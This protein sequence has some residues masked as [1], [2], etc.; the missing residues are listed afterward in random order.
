MR[1]FAGLDVAVGGVEQ[2]VDLRGP[3]R[4]GREL[5]GVEIEAQAE[6]RLRR[7]TH[8]DKR[9]QSLLADVVD[10]AHRCLDYPLTRPMHT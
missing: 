6:D 2:R 1:A 7:R 10:D 9:P 8:L 4:R 3:R 5:R